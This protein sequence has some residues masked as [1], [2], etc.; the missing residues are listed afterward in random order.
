MKGLAY[1]F[2]DF[3]PSSHFR[4]CFCRAVLH[5]LGQIVKHCRRHRSNGLLSFMI[6]IC[7]NLRSRF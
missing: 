6:A 3:R 4:L 5:A 7:T 2:A 1:P